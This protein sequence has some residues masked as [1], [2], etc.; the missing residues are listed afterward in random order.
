MGTV[1]QT[2][3]YDISYFDGKKTTLKHNAGYS[4]YERWRRHDG[5]DSLGE[6]WKD[7]AKKI[8]DDF[9]LG[10]KKV[11]EIGCAKGFIVEDL[12]GMG[13]DCYGL[14]VSAYAIGQA[15]NIV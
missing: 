14:D 6:F 4:K 9:S 12:R 15:S 7:K 8:F 5:V 2:S 1:L 3:E 11:M 13:V 10:G